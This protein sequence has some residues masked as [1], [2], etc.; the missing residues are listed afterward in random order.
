MPGMNINL[1]EKCDKIVR[2]Y[3]AEK[4]ISKED[5]VYEIIKGYKGGK[6]K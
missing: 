1:D 4:G 2:V 3:A 5:A 6:K